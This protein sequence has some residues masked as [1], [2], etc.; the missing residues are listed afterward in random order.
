[1]RKLILALYCVLIC[2]IGFPQ[3]NFERT[4]GGIT[5]D[6][7]LSVAQTTDKGY[8]ISGWT[9][10]FGS[11][12]YDIY[13]IKTDEYGDTLWTKTY[14]GYNLEMGYSVAQTY[15][16]GYI[17]AGITDSY[18]AGDYD[19][20]LIKTNSYGDSLWTK[21]FGGIGFDGGYSVLQAS[22]S[23]FILEGITSSFGAGSY[24]VYL[25]KID[26]NGAT[27]WTKTIG[28][29]LGDDF[30]YIAKTNDGGYIIA[31]YTA[32]NPLIN[33]NACLIKTNANG[34]T[35]WSRVYGGPDAESALSVVQ[36]SDGGYLFTGSTFNVGWSNI[37]LVKT[38]SSG[39]T[40]WT[41]IFNGIGHNVGFSVI[42]ASD[43]GYYMCGLI[44]NNNGSDNDVYLVKADV[45]GD[46][47]CS[48]TWGGI[49]GEIGYCIKN[50]NDGGFIIVGKTESFG[51][52]GSD[53]YLI[54]RDAA[55][56]VGRHDVLSKENRI[57]V[58][59]N[60]TTG[61]ININLPL[62]FGK[63]K[64]LGIYNG[65]GQLMEVLYN[66]SAIDIGSYKPGIYVFLITNEEG[67]SLTARVIKE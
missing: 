6:V 58:Y 37:Y 66:N 47:L 19:A 41:K 51:A 65:L 29:P 36:T 52:G 2:N 23:G 16:N 5:D 38:N 13:L 46:S 18:G 39:D 26:I 30:R 62:Q 40:T 59:P 12:F 60:P 49:L 50:T 10:S 24:D 32:P 56:V 21:T 43:G 42:Q 35:L 67:V 17:I 48:M 27:L 3:I 1:M 54:K 9:S 44:A 55:F 31:G 15:D 4:Y 57:N 14:G 33:G 61:R 34:D 45:N 28:G 11:G 25:I 64:S 53:V 7:G 20:Y 8:I 63:M 22:D